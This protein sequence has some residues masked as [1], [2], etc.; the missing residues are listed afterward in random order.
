LDWLTLLLVIVSVVVL[1][2]AKKDLKYKPFIISCVAAVM[3]FAAT[4]FEQIRYL[5]YV[6][7][8]LM[9]AA[10]LWNSRL[11]K[12]GFGFGKRKTKA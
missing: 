7:N 2:Y 11:N 1:Y 4:A 3:I 12:A 9:I 5:V 6:G 10:A 8:A